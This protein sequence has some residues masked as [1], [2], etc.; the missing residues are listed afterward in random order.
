MVKNWE[1]T[2]ASVEDDAGR[3]AVAG[4]GGP[5]DTQVID[6]G[7]GATRKPVVPVADCDRTMRGRERKGT[8]KHWQQQ[9]H[10]GQKHTQ[11]ARVGTGQSKDY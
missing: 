2:Q 4:E 11:V 7:A 1:A 6:D 9:Q 8:E 3:C 5:G 10:P